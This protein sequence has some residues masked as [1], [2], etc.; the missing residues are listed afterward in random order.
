MVLALV[1]LA[2]VVLALVVL[3]LVVLTLVVL[4]LVVGVLVLVVD[5]VLV[6]GLA[7]RLLRL[8]GVG[9]ALRFRGRVPIRLRGS[10]GL[11][12]GLGGVA[13]FDGL[14][15]DALV[16]LVGFHGLCPAWPM[17][18]PRARWAPMPMAR[19]CS[20]RAA[21]RLPVSGWVENRESMPRPL[22]GLIMNMW[23]VAGFCSAVSF[24]I[25]STA[26]AILANASASQT[27]LPAISPPS[28]SASY[29]R[30]REIAN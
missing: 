5:L 28:L 16:P 22:R 12:V 10:L 11:R 9:L 17:K 24:G 2:L 26:P 21:M 29:S 8:I 13:T 3:A 30:E 7:A 18:P 4:V 23:A 1:V 27:G 14:L 20:I 15:S 19:A 25:C 6:L